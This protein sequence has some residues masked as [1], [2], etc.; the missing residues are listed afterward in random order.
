MLKSTNLLSVNQTITYNTMVFIYKML[1]NLLPKHLLDKCTFVRDIHNHDT[2]SRNNFYL[3]MSSTNFGQNSL[4][5]KGLQQYNELPEYVKTSNSLPQF[6][7]K[8][9]EHVKQTIVL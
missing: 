7:R 1:N 2:R 6:K 9:I 8:C 5:Y 4:F 3:H